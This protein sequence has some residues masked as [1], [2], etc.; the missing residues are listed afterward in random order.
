MLCDKAVAGQDFVVRAGLVG[1]LIPLEQEFP[2]D[3]GCDELA[4]VSRTPQFGAQMYKHLRPC[5]T[6]RLPSFKRLHFGYM[7]QIIQQ[8]VELKLFAHHVNDCIG[9]SYPIP[10]YTFAIRHIII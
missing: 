1:E 3:L 6:L 9:R 8:R 4:L 2:S 7:A 5:H 10:L